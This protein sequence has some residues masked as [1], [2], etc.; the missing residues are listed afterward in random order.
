MSNR[1]IYRYKLSPEIIEDITRF[2]QMH[3]YVSR[4]VFREKWDEWLI[5]N[6]EQI[7]TEKTRLENL[8]YTKSVEKKLFISARYYFKNR[9]QKRESQQETTTPTTTTTPT[10]TIKR[11]TRI[12][13]ELIEKMDE[14][15]MSNPIKP[16]LS[17]DVFMDENRMLIDREITNYQHE[18]SINSQNRQQLHD[19]YREK[20]KKTYKNRYY[21]L[22]TK[23][24][25]Q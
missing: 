20:I 4:E 3:M 6:K 21:V 25:K 22:N 17:F 11:Y 19:E 10:P 13:S 1:A 7:A 23:T 24:R 8:G 2:S 15:I 18:P 16:A 5:K 14:M 9:S 12:S